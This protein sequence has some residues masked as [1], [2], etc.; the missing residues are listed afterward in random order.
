M[1]ITKAE[2]RNLL[3]QKRAALTDAECMKLDDLLLIQFQ[4][5]D[6]SSTEILASFYPLA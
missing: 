2:A 3:S 6:W 5:I 1:H 4:R